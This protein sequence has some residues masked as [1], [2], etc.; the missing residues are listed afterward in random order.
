MDG[1]GSSPL[2]ALVLFIGFVIVNAVMYAFGAAIQNVNA[3]EIERRAEE[4]SEKD[5]KLLRY[6]NNPAKFINT[7]QLVTSCMAVVV[8]YFQLE[9]YAK[10]VLAFFIRMGSGFYLADSVVYFAAYLLTALYL[11]LI[12]L[13]L[14][15]YVP[16]KL[17]VKYCDNVVNLLSGI[18][19][20]LV[21]LF[22]PFTW[23]V[24]AFS[25]LVLRVIGID[26]DEEVLNV[27]EEEIMNIVH[28]GHEQGVLEEEEAKMISNIIELDDKTAGDIM[29]HRKNIVAVNGEWT[30]KQTVEFICGQN[31]SRY[32]VYLDNIDNIIGILHIKEVLYHYHCND[33]D[34][35]AVQNIENLLH[36]P[37]FIPESRNLD[38]LFKEMQNHK[39]HMEI[40]VD[41][42]GQTAGL[43]TM[44]DILEEI[45]GNILDEHDEEEH[46][47]IKENDET[48]FV[49]G[50]TPLEEL[51][52]ILHI[53]FDE[54]EVDTLNGFV[55]SKL[56]RIP[57]KGEQA[58][59]TYKHCLFQ[60]VEVDGKIISLVKITINPQKDSSL[61]GEP[62]GEKD[63]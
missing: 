15:I 26:P 5:K 17:G 39:N 14:G 51:E 6:L 59:I 62:D 29:M 56:E 16:K 30:L 35:I 18:V 12:L 44:E 46:N 20:F 31:N 37:H 23:F 22:T 57:A 55:I 36:E 34:D 53:S 40:V 8:G 47:I 27:T 45:V 3:A 58:E 7:V 54:E 32:P 4:G 48:Y 63:K 21:I 2:Y 13:A 49:K 50:L 42:Y 19:D 9:V 52:E 25:N 10:N 43:V 24:T 61:G 28:E 60:V 41:E 33:C 1:S 11:M 38:D